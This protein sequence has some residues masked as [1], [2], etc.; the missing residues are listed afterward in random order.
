LITREIAAV[1]IPKETQ[2][3]RRAGRKG[4]RIFPSRRSRLR[5]GVAMSG[6]RV[7]RSRSPAKLSEVMMPEISSGINRKNGMPMILMGSTATFWMSEYWVR[8]AR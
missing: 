2:V 5:T 1:R 7:F 3:T 8:P 6:S 4:V